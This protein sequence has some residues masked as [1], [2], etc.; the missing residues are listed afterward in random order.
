MGRGFVPVEPQQPQ[1]GQR[2]FRVGGAATGSVDVL[3]AQSSQLR[4]FGFAPPAS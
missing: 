4:R 2:S 1:I 3:D